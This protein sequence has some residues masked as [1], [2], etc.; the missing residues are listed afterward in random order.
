VASPAGRP[1]TPA[2]DT[3]SLRSDLLAALEVMRSGLTGQGAALIL[4]LLVDAVLSGVSVTGFDVLFPGV[5]AT[6]P[7]L[8]V[9]EYPEGLGLG[10]EA[11]FPS[12]W[13]L[14]K[15]IPPVGSTGPVEPS[16]IIC[17]NA[18]V[19][20]DLASLIVTRQ[21]PGMALAGVLMSGLFS[22]PMSQR[23]IRAK[24]PQ[25]RYSR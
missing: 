17:R 7:V 6:P 22:S 14:L 18:W 12:T 5:L 2:P 9:A 16:L 23:F 24:T 19:L 4:G 3:G 21:V 20:K 1:A 8:R 25:P 10:K 15:S 11:G 13:V